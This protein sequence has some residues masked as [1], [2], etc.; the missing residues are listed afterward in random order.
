MT[1]PRATGEG[2]PRRYD[3]KIAVIVRDDLADWQKLHV[4]A[5][6]S[7]GIAHA[8]DQ[9]VGGTY[10]DASGNTYL[11]MFRGP[12]L[13]YTGYSPALT[14]AHTRALARGLTTALCTEEL[15]TTDNEDDHRAAVRAVAAEDLRLVGLAVYGPRSAV[16][17]VTKGLKLHG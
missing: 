10:E 1:P 11:P 2:P 5:R 13:V 4:T 16:V 14:R 17:K 9:V 8:T 15:F 3:T 12:V 6:L 7:S